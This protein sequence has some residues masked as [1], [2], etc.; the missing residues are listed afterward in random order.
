MTNKNPYENGVDIPEFVEKNDNDIDMSVFKMAE[1]GGNI[2]VDDEE[3]EEESRKLS[4][5]GVMIIGGIVIVLLLVASISGWIFGISKNNSLTKLQAEYDTVAAKLTEADST[6]TTLQNNITVLNAEMEKL[7]GSQTTTGGSTEELKG[8]KYKFAADISVRDGA[9]SKKFADFN[10]LPDA[11]ADCVYENDGQVTTRDGA[12]MAVSET[13][14]VDG[15]VWG[16]V[17]NNAWICIKYGGEE[18]ATKQ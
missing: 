18:W 6:I 11:V 17:A 14:E 9:G 8:D 4:P 15:N 16:K 3:Y 12:I 5:K 1:D 10:K 7:K 2:D 13:K